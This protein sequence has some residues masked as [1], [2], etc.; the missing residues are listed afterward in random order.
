MMWL[1]IFLWWLVGVISFLIVPRGSPRT[2]GELAVAVPMGVLG[3]LIWPAIAVAILA[4]ADFWSQPIFKR[5]P[6]GRA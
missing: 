4:Q 6:G 3:P 5:K 1:W 2:W